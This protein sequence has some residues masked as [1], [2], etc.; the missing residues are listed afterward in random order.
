MNIIQLNEAIVESGFASIGYARFE[1]SD[2]SR[3][4]VRKKVSQMLT[5]IDLYS[6]YK[7]EHVND[8]AP[9]VYCYSDYEIKNGNMDTSKFMSEKT[10]G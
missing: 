5:S 6:K 8:I 9:T 2:W 3:E 4:D 10:E 1:L 7:G